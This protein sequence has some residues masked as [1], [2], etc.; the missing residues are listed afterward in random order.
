[1]KVIVYVPGLVL[2]GNRIPEIARAV[3]FTL[4]VCGTSARFDP[5]GPTE[6]LS[7]T[8]PLNP[9]TDLSSSRNPP[10]TVPAATSVAVVPDTVHT[11]AVCDWK[12][13]GSPEL[14]EAVSAT[15]CPTVPDGIELKESLRSLRGRAAQVKWS[16]RGRAA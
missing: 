4:T 1:M 10:S 15:F 3:P 14:A 13:T 8:S 5:A 9:F 6:Q 16:V 2:A 7:V 11:D 12:P